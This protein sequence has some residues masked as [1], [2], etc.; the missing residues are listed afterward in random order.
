MRSLVRLLAAAVLAIGLTAPAAAQPTTQDLALPSPRLAPED[1]LRRVGHVVVIF[2]ENRGLDHLFGRFPGANGLAQ[3]GD[4][5]VQTG[6]DGAPLALLPPVRDTSAQGAPVDPRFPADL[7]NAPFPIDR[8]VP[9]D[10]KTGDLV[11]R[12]YQEQAQINGGRMDRFVAVSNAGGLTMGH[13]DASG[14]QLW[15]LAREF[16]LGDNMF[17][18]A[19]GGSFL[20]HAFLVCAQAFVW[21]DAP[22]ELVIQLDADGRLVRD[23]QVTQDGFVVNT[24]L[25]AQFHPAGI[26]PKKLVPPQD[27]PHIG[28]RLDAAGV[29]WRWYAGG[30][31]DALAGRRTDDEFQYHHQPFAYFRNLAPGT[32]GQQAHLKDLADLYADISAGTLPPVMFYKPVGRLNLHPGYADI[33][34]GDEHLGDLVARLQAGPQYADMLILITF[35]ENG[36][37][38]DHVPP[39]VRDR[40]GPGTRV[41]LI[42]VGPMVRRGNVDHTQYDFGSILRTIEDRFGLEPLGLLDGRNTT[43]RNLLQ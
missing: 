18:S 1:P 2:L 3:A 5:A 27:M 26:D 36:G 34:D 23:G 40:W 17:H 20:N 13:Y 39:P 32:P 8:Y 12:F 14:T 31:A 29:D 35:D 24:S 41:P 7:P 28:D 15:R 10:Q 16:A 42:A 21:P 11:H 9:A 6:P 37:F 22:P 4:R 33:R 38:W 19:F 25:S 30:Y 43:M